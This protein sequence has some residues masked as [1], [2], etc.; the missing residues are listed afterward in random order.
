M[1]MN[2]GICP[3][4]FRAAEGAMKMPNKAEEGVDLYWKIGQD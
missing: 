3:Y 1:A 2:G 4:A